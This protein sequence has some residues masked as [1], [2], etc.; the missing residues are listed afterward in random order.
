VQGGGT[1][2]T[3]P[4]RLGEPGIVDACDVIHAIVARRLAQAVHPAA[5][6]VPEASLHATTG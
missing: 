1:G 6:R 5:D 4:Y 3:V 2:P